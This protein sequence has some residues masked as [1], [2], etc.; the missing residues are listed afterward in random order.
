MIAHPQELQ[1]RL[2]AI[3]AQ[4]EKLSLPAGQDVSALLDTLEATKR[5]RQ[6]MRTRAKAR[7]SKEPNALPGWRI[8]LANGRGDGEGP[9]YAPSSRMVVRQHN[10]AASIKLIRRRLQRKGAAA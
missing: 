10:R 1:R 6:M 4:L 2:A 9:E 3:L 7:L 8:S 5:V